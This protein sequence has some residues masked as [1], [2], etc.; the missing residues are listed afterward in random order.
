MVGTLPCM[1][2]TRRIDRERSRWVGGT[3]RRDMS[4]SVAEIMEG[5]GRGSHHT[6]VC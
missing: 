2:N 5:A 3:R 6:S 1:G 4:K